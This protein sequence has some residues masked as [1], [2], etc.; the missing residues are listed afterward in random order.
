MKKEMKTV[1]YD[2]ELGVEAYRFKGIVQPFPNHFHEHYVIGFVEKGRR[3]LRCGNREYTIGEG[4]AVLFHPGDSHACTQSD[5]GALDYRSLNI[6]RKTMLALSDEV[7]GRK[8][9]PRFSENVIS[10]HEINCYLRPL[11]EMIMRGTGDFGRETALLLLISILIQN[12]GGPFEEN[13]PECRQEIERACRFIES[14]YAERIS[15]DQICRCAGLGKSTLLRAFA[16]EKGITPYRYL[17]NIRINEAKRLLSQGMS[18]LD[19]AMRTG[20]SDQSHFT[21]YFSSF[22]GLSPGVYRD[23][24]CCGG[25][26]GELFEQK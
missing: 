4:D 26:D 6:S 8:E 7:A 21:N 16:R 2:E 19:A 13:I 3:T 18:P 15:L 11:H 1:V 17:E 24:F 9:L 5:G 10:D 23:I 14:H 12:Y 22:I 25:K 20:F